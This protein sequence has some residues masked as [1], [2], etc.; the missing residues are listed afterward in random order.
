ML[1]ARKVHGG[2]WLQTTGM[3]LLG[4]KLPSSTWCWCMPRMA[5]ARMGCCTQLL[6]S[7]TR[8]SQNAVKAT[9]QKGWP[10]GSL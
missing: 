2:I 6:D 8:A 1:G 7:M 3:V 4:V 10:T 5:V 9:R